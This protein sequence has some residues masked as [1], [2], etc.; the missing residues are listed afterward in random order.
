MEQ[1]REKKRIPWQ[2]IAL[3]VVLVA[4]T[5]GWLF[6]PVDEWAQAFHRWIR[7][8]GVWGGVMFAGV[9]I[10]CTVLPAPGIPL[11]LVAGLAFGVVWGVI[12][13]LVS[14]TI[15]AT[16]AFLVARY[17]ARDKVAEMAKRHPKLQAIDKAVSE[18]GWTMVALL[19]LSPLIPFHFQNYFYGVT[20]IKFW[21]YVSATLVGMV[22]GT[23]MYVYL[24]AAGKAVLGIGGD[25]GGGGALKWGLLAAGLVATVIVTVLV[26]RKAKAKLDEISL[27]KD[28]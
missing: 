21:Q 28:A 24:G 2:W 3:G 18:E 12:L 11:S 16:L 6:L 15:G 4:V 1:F 17:L 20:D 14:A 19:R 23:L 9:Y 22:P 8:L 10:L 7:Q 25:A 5:V 26:T 13:V 27:E